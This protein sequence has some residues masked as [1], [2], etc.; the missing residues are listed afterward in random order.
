MK[1]LIWIILAI[2]GFV[3]LVCIGIVALGVLGAAVSSS[4][5]NGPTVSATS[6]PA[7]VENAQPAP[8]PGPT[9]APTAKAQPTSALEPQPTAAPPPPPTVEPTPEPTPEPTIEPTPE[10]IATPEGVGSGQKII[11]VDIQPGTYRTRSENANCYWERVS[12]F[13]GSISDIIAN[14][15]I[16]GPAIVTIQPDDV[17]FNSSRCAPWSD[18]LSPITDDPNAPFNQGFYMV[19]T[20]I[21][22][23]LWRAEG[24]E[25]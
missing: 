9:N 14:E 23:G 13:G 22:P 25:S 21:S 7:V 12:G 15:N 5:S 1:P 11:G 18:D 8:K 6:A 3:V 17:G 16:D 19:G 24:V 10:P 4:G 20:D 2:V